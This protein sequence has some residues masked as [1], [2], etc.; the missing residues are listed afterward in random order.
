MFKGSILWA[1]IMV[2]G[3]VAGDA[4][5]DIPVLVNLKSA[6]LVLVGTLIGGLLSAPVNTVGGFI[7]NISASLKRKPS[8]PEELIRQIASLGRLRRTMGI[9]ELSV[10]YEAVENPF[11]RQGLLQVLDQRNRQQV[12]E[13]M[14]KKISLYLS[15]LQSHLAVIQYFVKLAPVFGFVGTII[16]LINVLN[17]MGDASQIGYGM[18]ISLLTTFYGLL[19]ANFLFAPLAGKLAVH[20]Q[21][22][23]VTLN[24]V[25]EG[26]M[27]IFD[28][29]ASL[30]ITHRLLSYVEA[31]NSSGMREDTVGTRPWQ[32]W[33][34]ATK[35]SGIAR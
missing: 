17:H 20:I 33:F 9:R 14:E 32:K 16:G 34:A 26:V 35:Q 24:I 21:R 19:L 28:E 18:A 30:E 1:G 12:E 31:G 8:D 6:V 4:I 15:G 13:G 7:H 22:E 29:C 2:F 3:I 25:I 27:A 5:G 11:L 23:T 10:R